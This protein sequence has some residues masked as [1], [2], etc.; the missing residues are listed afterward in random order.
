MC[1]LIDS[2]RCQ[3][4]C[5][6]CGPV[7]HGMTTSWESLIHCGLMMTY[8]II[9]FCHHW[10]KGWIVLCSILS[11]AKKMHL[12]IWLQTPFCSCLSVLTLYGLV[13]PFITRGSL[14]QAIC[15]PPYH[16]LNI[17]FI[18]MMSSENEM[19]LTAHCPGL[20]FITWVFM[21]SSGIV[22]KVVTP[23]WKRKMIYSW[24]ILWPFFSINT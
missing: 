21:T 6:S 22:I 3:H 20:A 10:F 9:K 14:F 8:S 4:W 16:N 7:P 19:I 12:K 2:Q 18:M 24:F 13:M 17:L 5:R 15:L 11:H 23:T 1:Y